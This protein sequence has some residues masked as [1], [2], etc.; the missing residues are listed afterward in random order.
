MENVSFK[1]LKMN[2]IIILLLTFNLYALTLS[3]L[4]NSGINNSDLLDSI[5]K[6][7]AQNQE[8]ITLSTQFENPK[9]SI[10]GNSLPSNQAMSQQ[11]ISFSQKIPYFNKLEEI[12][13]ITT[14][15]EEI[16]KTQKKVAEVELVKE[17]KVNFYTLWKFKELYQIIA[18]YE[19]ITQHTLE[20][21]ETYTTTSENHHMGIMSAR[22]SLSELK[23][24]KS[25]LE[26]KIASLYAA[27]SYLSA[28]AV[29]KLVDK[30]EFDMEITPLPSKDEIEKNIVTKSIT[31]QL[32]D[33]EITK[34]E[35][36][37]K[38]RELSLYPDFNLLAAYSHREKFSDFSTV[39]IAFNI[40]IYANEKHTI[41]RERKGL[42]VIKSLKSDQKESQLREF[43]KAY[44]K[45]QSAY[46]IYHII[47]DEALAQ[48]EHMFELSRANIVTGADLFKYNDIL[49]KKLKL[50]KRS[51]EATANFKIAEAQI[52]AILGEL[53]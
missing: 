31:L 22:L 20:L 28:L 17:I 29:D 46:K 2:I 53:Q 11:T 19:D 4:I 3:E 50:E 40:P 49:L 36:V 16:L 32:K 33:Y 23:I 48:L 6:K 35:R 1:G 51:I 8:S 18:N 21:S 44:F 14:A 13:N 45:M 5:E 41:E 38:S 27:L 25:E 26:A 9:L 39:G 37:I 47:Q 24:Q 10:A 42:A 12:K 43:R 30:L 34:Q 7:I 52:E 15:Q